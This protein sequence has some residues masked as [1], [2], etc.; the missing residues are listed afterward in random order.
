M[1]SI[2]KKI[3]I[4]VL[5]SCYFGG[6]TQ[7]IRISSVDA[8]GNQSSTYYPDYPLTFVFDGYDTVTFN[9]AADSLYNGDYEYSIYAYIGGTPTSS[10][11]TLVVVFDDGTS[12]ALLPFN[13]DWRDGYFEYRIDPSLLWMLRVNPISGFLIYS[14]Y[15]VFSCNV[16]Y[17]KLYIRDFLRRYR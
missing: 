3:V 16:E 5:L 10:D 9:V 12:T 11:Y 7:D 1:E 14:D 13:R 2:F 17:N 15:N 6:Y 8:L 4:A